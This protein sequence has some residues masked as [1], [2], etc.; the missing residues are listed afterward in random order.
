ML[1]KN[2]SDNIGNRTCNIPAY[3]TMPQQTV[4]PL[5]PNCKNLQ[6]NQKQNGFN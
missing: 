6:S 4:P 2:S 3:S 1:M 5:A